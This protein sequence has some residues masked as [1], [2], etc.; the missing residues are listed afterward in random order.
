ARRS[1]KPLSATL[2]S[3]SKSIDLNEC[4]TVT[5]H[6]AQL[7]TILL[8]TEDVA[9]YGAAVIFN[10]LYGLLLNGKA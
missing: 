3:A 5:N 6:L 7:F 8:L 9:P 1:W 2:R 10:V 4:K